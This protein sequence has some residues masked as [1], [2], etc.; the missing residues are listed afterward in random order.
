ATRPPYPPRASPPR[1]PLHRD[2]AVPAHLQ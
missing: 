2:V 1:P